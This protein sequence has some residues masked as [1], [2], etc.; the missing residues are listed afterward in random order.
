MP[1]IINNLIFFSGI[2]SKIFP[3]ELLDVLGYIFMVISEFGSCLYRCR[4]FSKDS[5]LSDWLCYW[6]VDLR[7]LVE[8]H[9]PAITFIKRL[10]YFIGTIVHLSFKFVH[11][12]YR[13]FYFQPR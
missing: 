4:P 1:R 3:F 2:I 12:V 6:C 10:L 5:F 8:P 11:I 13:V 9:L 7:L